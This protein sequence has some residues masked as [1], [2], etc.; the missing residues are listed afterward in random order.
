LQGLLIAALAIYSGEHAR[1]RFKCSFL[2]T[3]GLLSGRL[4]DFW[5]I[6]G[7]SKPRIEAPNAGDSVC[8]IERRDKQIAK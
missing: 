7:I 6:S 3:T 5:L 8:K 4:K 1:R 2:G